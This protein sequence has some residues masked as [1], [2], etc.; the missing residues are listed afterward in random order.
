MIKLKIVV[1]DGYT[2][3]PGDLDWSGIEAF[4]D[5]RVYEHTPEDLVV[6]RAQGAEIIFTNKTPLTAET[7]DRLEGLRYIGVLA[8]GY[9]VVDVKG[10]S[11]RGIVVTNI[12]T[13]GT[14]SVA[15][16]VFAHILE[17]CRHVQIHS[18]AV[19]NGE[20]SNC[21]DF[22]FW[23]T[24]QV[25]LYG[26]TIGIVGFGNIGRQVGKIADAMGMKVIAYDK[27]ANN[28][29]DFEGFRWVNLEELFKESDVISLHCPLFPETK[30]MVNKNTLSL[31]KKTAF[32]INTSRGG[33]VVDQDLADALNDGQIAGA[34][35]DVVS[36]EPPAEDNPLLKAK[37][38][39]ITPH[40]AW[41]TKEARQRLMDIAVNNLKC[42]LEGNPVNV[43]SA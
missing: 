5:T 11:D 41:A 22:C 29:P 28:P 40:I 26:K 1:L 16:M 30:G 36:I 9:N 2:L 15:Q 17:L 37:N 4:G 24:P 8:T 20:W 18:D 13:Y 7:M 33:L 12:P 42:F 27:I 31:M 39:L 6:E 25:E 35:L 21:R 10:A 14:H 43:V 19:R 34:G 38:C 23:K 3:N 32:L